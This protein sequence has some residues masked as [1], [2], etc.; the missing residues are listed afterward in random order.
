MNEDLFAAIHRLNAVALASGFK[1]IFQ[2]GL[3]KELLL[4]QT[5]GHTILPKKH[6]PDAVTADGKI[7]EYLSCKEGGAGQMDRMFK[8]PI[9]KR[10]RSLDRIARNDLIILAIYDKDDPL[11]LLRVYDLGKDAVLREAERQLDRW[12]SEIAHIAFNEKFALNQ[13]TK[14][15]DS[16]ESRK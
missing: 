11:K 5:L 6:G 7:C 10:T 15:W 14:L 13:G 2:P 4:A 3:V 9:E 12:P 1:N 8:A 16:Q